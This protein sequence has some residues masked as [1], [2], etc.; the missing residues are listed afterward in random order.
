MNRPSPKA[1]SNAGSSRYTFGTSDAAARR[2][3]T[4]ARFF[5]IP[6]EALI[7]R[8]ITPS[9][10]SVLDLGCGPGFTTAMLTRV[11]PHAATCGLDKSDAFLKLARKRLPQCEFLKH[12]ITL[13]PSPRR[14]S[15]LYTRFLLSHL[16]EP[17]ALVNRWISEVG[18]EW[19]V[20]EELERIETSVD[21]F[22]RY[23]DTNTALITSQGADLCVG[24]VLGKGTYR[25][26]VICN[27][28]IRLPVPNAQAAEWFLPNAHT[29]WET[30]PFVRER[31][32]E[33]ARCAVRKEL[34]R[35]QKSD[36]RQ[37]DI[38]W[39]MRRLVLRK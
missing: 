38:T 33:Q 27:E 34:Q 31:L 25:A 6:S 26:E 2:L 21:V 9:A 19:I 35:I 39:Y 7:A 13:A 1:S 29:I 15:L 16:P 12:D 28:T 23:L 36:S 37:S 22:R 10:D 11:L 30:E 20:V 8:Y 32:S 24:R 18:N 5:D 4:I 17:V 14:A 3:G